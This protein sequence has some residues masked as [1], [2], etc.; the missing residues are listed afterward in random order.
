ME[1]TIFPALKALT[2]KDTE[3]ARMLLRIALHVL[4]V[5]AVNVIIIASDDLRDLLP[6][7]DPLC[8]KCVDPVDCL[9]RSTIDWARSYPSP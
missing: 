7:D 1:H 5:K 9:T 3:G 4:L 6:K 2:E 8:K